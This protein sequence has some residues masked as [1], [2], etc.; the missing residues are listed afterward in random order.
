MIREH[1]FVLLKLWH[2]V[3]GT[4]E[5]MCGLA[6]T[7]PISQR[8]GSFG[9]WRGWSTLSLLSSRKLHP[10]ADIVRHYLNKMLKKT[11]TTQ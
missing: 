4:S 2:F 8:L 7:T 5:C 10:L 9:E 3:S 1:V 11:V 6:T